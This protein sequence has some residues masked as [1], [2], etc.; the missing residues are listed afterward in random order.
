M[1]LGPRSQVSERFRLVRLLGEGG[2]GCVWEAEHQTLGVP[3]ALKFI[4]KRGW[5]HSG[6]IERFLREARVAARLR[7]R[8]GRAA[9]L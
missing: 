5:T 2:M 9:S 4:S 8:M 3:V 6:V 7:H 1:Q